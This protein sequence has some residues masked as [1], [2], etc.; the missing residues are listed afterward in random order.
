MV[1]IIHWGLGAMGTRIAALVRDRADMVS[2]G[3]IDRDPAK[4]GKTLDQ[5][6]ARVRLP[7]VPQVLTKTGQVGDRGTGSPS[8]GRLNGPA[9]GIVVGSPEDVLQTPADLV[10]LATGSFVEEVAPQ[11][12]LALEH[13]LNVITIAE[14]MVFPEA[15]AP[16]H[17]QE[18]DRMARNRGA[19]V[20]GTGINPGFVMDTLVICLTGVCSQ[21]RHIMVR[22]ANDLSPYGPTVMAG[23]GVGLTPQQFEDGVASGRVVG[24]VGFLQSLGLIARALGWTLD[25][26]EQSREP[27]V[28]RLM[29]ETPYVKVPPGRV[30]GCRHVARGFKNGREV[31]FLDHPQQVRPE[32]EG[33]ETGDEI[34]IRGQPDIS[35]R[36]SPEIPGGA[37]TAAIAVNMVPVVMAAEPGLR[38]MADLPLPRMVG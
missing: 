29:R 33:F 26:I 7:A 38:T 27:I 10:I 36:T 11:V 9:G 25:R 18:I 1:R 4:T 28:A 12:I 2:V 37:G 21:V 30:A 8:P 31:I 20:L 24:H 16:D 3:A 19:V 5:L 13:G 23:Q 14:E 6:L 22:R 35:L 15:T 17:A 34:R 32:L